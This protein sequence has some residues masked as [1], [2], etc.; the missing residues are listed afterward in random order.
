MAMPRGGR[1]WSVPGQPAVCGDVFDILTGLTPLDVGRGETVTIAGELADVR[2][3]TAA[4]S[5]WRIQGAPVREDDH[6]RVWEP[7]GHRQLRAS[8]GRVVEA[9]PRWP[10]RRSGAAAAPVPSATGGSGVSVL[11]LAAGTY[12]EPRGG[13]EFGEL[14]LAA[15]AAELS[16]RVRCGPSFL[17]LLR[18]S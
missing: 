7:S 17:H 9:Q 4:A 16:R 11:G 10:Q 3:R 6:W 14:P 13:H 1:C 15:P 12:K 2:F 18:W 8:A 5:I